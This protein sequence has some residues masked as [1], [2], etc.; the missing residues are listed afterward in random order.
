[1]VDVRRQPEAVQLAETV[2][3]G[4]LGGGESVV[5]GDQGVEAAAGFEGEEGEEAVDQGAVEGF[6]EL[7]ERNVGFLGRED[8]CGDA[9]G[10]FERGG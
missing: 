1:M 2:D 5:V 3:P 4:S 9:A 6:V 8:E 10:A 7:A